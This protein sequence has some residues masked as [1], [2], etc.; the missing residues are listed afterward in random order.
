MTMFDAVSNRMIFTYKMVQKDQMDRITLSQ[1]VR[2]TLPFTGYWLSGSI[3]K[4]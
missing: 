1:G 2:A 4:L 3:M